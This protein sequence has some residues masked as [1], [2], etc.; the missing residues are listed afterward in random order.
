MKTLGL[1]GG[2]SWESTCSYYRLLN[3]LT[4]ERLGGSHSAPLLLYSFDFDRLER[5]QREERWGDI[6]SALVEAARTLECAGA[7][8]LL[9][10]TNTM[11]L[12]ADPVRKSIRIP[13]LHIAD[14]TGERLR[15]N[16]HRRV[17]L[18]GTRFTMEKDFYKRHLS[19]RF[20][21]E[22]SVPH[23]TDRRQI[24]RIIFEE[25]VRGET[26]ESSRAFFARVI[27]DFAAEGCEAIVLGCTEIGLLVSQSDSALPLYDTT[28]LHAEAAIDLALAESGQERSSHALPHHS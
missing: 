18:L 10:C 28:A 11:H 6:E 7:E 23:E 3:R 5:W 1:L 4:R 14:V 25:L 2:M 24:H 9:L 26:K 8:I 22:V 20:E 15:R 17:A 16:G 12:V 21:L 19:E 13:F 27:G